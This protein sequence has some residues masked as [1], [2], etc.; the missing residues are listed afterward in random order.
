VESLKEKFVRLNREEYGDAYDRMKWVTEEPARTA[1]LERAGILASLPE[2]VRKG[3]Y[4][5]KVHY[6]DLSPGCH[7]C[8]EGR[9]S[10]LFINSRCNARCFYCPSPQPSIAEPVTNT[11]PFPDP[12]DY[13]DYLHAFG[14]QGMSVSGGEPLLTFDRTLRFISQTKRRFGASLHVW[15][16]TNGILVTQEKLRQLWEAGLDEIRFDLSANHYDL[17]KVQWAARFI[18]TVTVEVPAIPEDEERLLASL[19]PMSQAGAKH[20]NLH[21]LRCTPH[22]VSRLVDRGYTFLHGPRVTVLESEFTALRILRQA[23]REAIGLSVNYCS[24]VYKDRFQTAAYRR[25][26]AG[27]LCKPYEAVTPA[28]LIRRITLKG[29]PERIEGIS[30]SLAESGLDTTLWHCERSLNTL[31]FHDSLWP[32]VDFANVSLFVSYDAPQMKPAISYRGVFKEVALNRRKKIF[33]ERIPVRGETAIDPDHLPSL[34]GLLFGSGP[35]GEM[36]RAEIPVP[37]VEP[38]MEGIREFEQVAWG[39]QEYF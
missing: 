11:I 17:E 25:R 36:A 10:C 6:L 28:G 31:S 21:Q 15:L 14:F 18:E 1:S 9:W 19:I 16:Y 5:T 26:Q 23:A 35:E 4:G 30:R 7:I 27:L 13:D 33:I 3:Y 29:E 34:H 2:G 22:N 20:L 12:K 37:E 39:L 8:G 24:F 32:Y 38:L